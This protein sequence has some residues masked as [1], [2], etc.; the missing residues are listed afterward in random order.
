MTGCCKLQLY[1]DSAAFQA[2]GYSVC[3]MQHLG[4]GV[5]LSAVLYEFA[6]SPTVAQT[7]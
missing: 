6:Q 7:L 3:N 5:T 1:D 2:E 4:S